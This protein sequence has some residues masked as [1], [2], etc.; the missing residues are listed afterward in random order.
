M[1]RG[2]DLG[3]ADG[4]GEERMVCEEVDLSRE[5]SGGLEQGF[6]GGGLKEGEF[7]AGASQAVLDVW[8]DLV[9]GEWGQVIADD[10]ALGQGIDRLEAYYRSCIP[11]D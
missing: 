8:G 4:S 3:P 5:S 10:D 11:A 2:D 7:C 9:A 1:F 6:M